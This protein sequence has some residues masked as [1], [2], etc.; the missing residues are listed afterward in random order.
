MER[1]ERI[2]SARAA[3]LDALTDAAGDDSLCTLGRERLPSVK[4]HEGAV[5]AL[6]DA[7][8]AMRSGGTLPDSDSWGTQW[9]HLMHRDASWRAYVLGGREAL[10]H[11]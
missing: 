8:R 2:A 11:L 10:A 6:N 4:F 1:I 5:A 3:A 9:T 7:L